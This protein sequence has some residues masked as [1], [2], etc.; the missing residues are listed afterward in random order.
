ML[1]FTGAFVA[2]TIWPIAAGLYW[3][4]TNRLGATLGMILGSAVGLWTYFSIGFYVAALV[5]AAVSMACVVVFTFAAPE[6]FEWDRLREN[7]SGSRTS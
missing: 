4:K 5:G 6:D 1:Y 2:S 3:K 7:E